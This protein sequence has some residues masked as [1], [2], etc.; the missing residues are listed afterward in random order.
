MLARLV[1]EGDAMLLGKIPEHDD[2][3]FVARLKDSLAAGARDPFEAWQAAGGPKLGYGELAAIATRLAV[4][5]TADLARLA[6]SEAARRF[7]LEAR[8]LDSVA[9][10]IASELSASEVYTDFQQ[11][12][13]RA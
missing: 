5:G 2:T 10:I 4:R 7:P 6:L 3:P 13:A 1:A 11:T 8:R 12:V 9:R